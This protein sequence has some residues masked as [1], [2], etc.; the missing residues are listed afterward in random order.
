MWQ[1]LKKDNRET[2][3][4]L[5]TEGAIQRRRGR[6]KGTIGGPRGKAS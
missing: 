6:A 1:Y 4:Q 3:I 2:E 5:L